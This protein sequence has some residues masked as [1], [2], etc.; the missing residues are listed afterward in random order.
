MPAAVD[1]ELDVGQ[2]GPPAKQAA[3]PSDGP[4]ADYAKPSAQQSDGPW[5]DYARPKQAPAPA[6]VVPPTPRVPEEDDVPQGSR[7]PQIPTQAPPT[8]P[9]TSFAPEPGNTEGTYAMQDA[10]GKTA[11]VPYSKVEAAK[12]QGYQLPGQGEDGRATGEAARYQHDRLYD[13]K[14]Q[15]QTQ[16][17][18]DVEGG[19]TLASP[20]IQIGQGIQNLTPTPAEQRARG[21]ILP[22]LGPNGEPIPDVAHPGAAMSPQETSEANRQHLHGLAQVLAGG[23]EVG[24]ILGA[25]ELLGLAGAAATGDTVAIA[26]L[27]RIGIS[28]GVGAGASAGAGAAAKKLKLSPEATELAQQAAFWAGAGLTGMATHVEPIEGNYGERGVRVS[29][30][31]VSAEGSVRPAYRAPSPEGSYG[32]GSRVVPRDINAR[33]TVGGKSVGTAPKGGPWEDYAPPVEKPVPKEL[34]TGVS[35]NAVKSDDSG[36]QSRPV[37]QASTDAVAIRESAG[38][39]EK[40]TVASVEKAV[41]DVDGVEVNGS[42]V[43]DEDSQQNKA[44]RDKPVETQKDHLGVR[45]AADTPEAQRAAVGAIAQTMPVVGTEPLENNGLKG[46]QVMV[47]TGRPG[48]ANQVSEIQVVPKSQVEAMKETDKLY[49]QQKEALAAGNTAKAEALGKQITEIHEAALSNTTPTSSDVG[50]PEDAVK[51]DKDGTLIGESADTNSEGGRGESPELAGGGADNALPP[52][53][54]ASKGVAAPSEGAISKQVAPVKTGDAVKLPDGRRG[55]VK[56]ISLGG[57]V[58][59]KLDGG[60]RAK[61]RRG[62]VQPISDDAVKSGENGSP[63]GIVSGTPGHETPKHGAIA[64]DLDKT[65]ATYEG[66]K[67]P[68]VIGK[69]IS[70]QVDAVKKMLADGE[71]VW[72]F[73]ARLEHPKAIPALKAWTKEHIGTELPMTNIKF[74]EFSRFIDD[75]AELPV[76]MQKEKNDAVQERSAEEVGAHGR[77]DEGA[78]RT[79]RGKGVGSEQQGDEAPDRGVGRESSAGQHKEVQGN[80][81]QAKEASA[82]DDYDRSHPEAGFIDLSDLT[83]LAAPLREELERRSDI[84]AV[85]H[86]AQSTLQR[87]DKTNKAATL[88]AKGIVRAFQ[89]SGFTES[90]GN[91]V[92]ANL[93]DPTVKLTSQQMELRDKWI[94]PLDQRA[95]MQRRIALLIKS[96][97]F[98]IEDILAGRVPK[99]EV[100]RIAPEQENYQHRIAQDKNTFVDKMLGDSMKRFRAPG[101]ALSRS[102]SSSKRSVFQE[103]RGTNGEREAVA[104]KGGRVTQFVPSSS[105]KPTTVDLGPYRSGFIDTKTIADDA[106]APLERKIAAL[107]KERGILTETKGREAV[108]QRRLANIDTELASLKKQVD[109]VQQS[110]GGAPAKMTDNEALAARLAPIRKV[111]DRLSKQ[112]SDLKATPENARNIARLTRRI[113]ENQGLIE[114]IREEHEGTNLQGQYW[115]DKDGNLWKFHRGTTKFITERTGQ[116]YH[117]NAMLSSLVNYME[118]NKAMNAAVVMERSKGLLENEGMAL[119]TE[120]PATVPD[121]WKPTTLLQMHGMYF[122]AHIADAF[123]QFDYLQSRGQPNVMERANRFIIQTVLMNP[124][125]HGKNVVANFF[126]G[127]AAEA[128]T[129]SVF[130]PSWYKGNMEAGIKATNT[131]K[132]IGGPEYRRLLRLGLDLQAADSSFDQTTKDILRSFTDQLAKDKESNVAM[133]ALMKVGDAATWLQHM[134]HLMTFGIN[135]LFLLQSFYAREAELQARGVP[136]PSEAARDWAHL[137]VAEYTTP[138]RVGG[139]AALGRLMENPNLSAF[140]RYHFGGILRPVLSAVAEAVGPFKAVDDDLG[141]SGDGEGQQRKRNARGQ[142]EAEART[143]AIGRLAVMTLM[144]TV[145]FPKILDKL[146]KKITGDAQAKAPRGGVLGFAS[147]IAETAEG[148]RSPSSLAGSVFTPA[149]GTEELVE[150]GINRDFFTGKH[151]MGTNVG[152]GDKVR[153]LAAWLGSKSTPGQMTHRMDQGK[154]KQ[155]MWSLLGFTFPMEHGLK[156]AAEIRGEASGSN[157]SDPQKA[158]VFQSILAASEQARRSDGK[159]TRLK[160]ALLNSGKLTPAQRRELIQASHETP[161]VFATA[162][163]EHDE[164]VW[165]VYRHSTDEEKSELVADPRTGRRLRKYE[166]QLRHDGK[167]DEAD[168]IA[169]VLPK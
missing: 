159:D 60:G 106:T 19:R 34:G 130:R 148:E 28:A 109:A 123:D 11:Q 133:S 40:P 73:T 135:D 53:K 101:A 166:R 18:A 54:N 52:T 6:T 139:S 44:D 111:V 117:A 32:E 115:R 99:E 131:L 66:Y 21:P 88:E 110:I 149:L 91:A 167:N 100:D 98:P 47:R 162:D 136:N 48:E 4:W 16:R 1:E 33:V 9:P 82:V 87:L 93:E 156:E 10:T 124:L 13:P 152:T 113:Q 103:I 26:A 90:D 81:G 138:A 36:S 62:D 70:P 38:A 72:I 140:W 83:N 168:Q 27:T 116:K 169:A 160:D 57:D 5:A 42:R 43:K 56:G 20:A 8:P 84:A 155:V 127:K 105:G 154:G 164:D 15:L 132:D 71:D 69:P 150:A 80:G 143:N 22:T 7:G 46:T 85:A 108:S 112:K 25:P 59:V 17:A 31:G 39:Q 51:S 2:D 76:Q 134:N 119:K 3:P 125:M 35:P 157:P 49:D 121:G 89:Q 29:V 142:T 94:K 102:F 147:D 86:D 137:Q 78:G 128:I 107:K 151:I 146:A 65:L 114:S 153:Q 120:N 45:V 95:A 79:E 58:E 12:Q 50:K 61:A 144:A 74:P 41:A 122:P 64:I 118:T 104:V 75:R 37:V 24:L 55:V 96:G 161:I 14:E 165:R 77:G 92:F 63:K 67:G 23:G 141:I 158:K 145:V 126:T 163:L 97:E 30:P 68:T 129:G